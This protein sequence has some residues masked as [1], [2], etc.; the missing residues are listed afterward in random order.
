MKKIAIILTNSLLIGVMSGY[1]TSDRSSTSTETN[2]TTSEKNYPIQF[3]PVPDGFE[4]YYHD[5]N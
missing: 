3:L 2:T 1:A 5:K 4:A